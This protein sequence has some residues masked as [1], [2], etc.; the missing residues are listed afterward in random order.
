MKE[1]WI[2]GRLVLKIIKWI[3]GFALAAAIIFLIVTAIIAACKNMAY[4]EYLRQLFKI[5]K[6]ASETLPI[7]QPEAVQTLALMF[8]K[9]QLL[10]FG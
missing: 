7:E 1:V 9:S 8:K 2:L 3:F 5:A 10:V 6:Q 4:A